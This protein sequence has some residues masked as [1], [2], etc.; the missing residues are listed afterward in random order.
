MSS[1]AFEALVDECFGR[2]AEPVD[3]VE[4]RVAQVFADRRVIVWEGDAQ[5]FEFTYV[6][7]AAEELLG[8]PASRWTTE[9]T[10]WADV[11]VAPA[12]RG[13]AIAYCALAT[14][15]RRHHA[16]D[17]RAHAADGR[18]VWLR[19]YVRVIVGPRGIAT[20]LR[21]LMFDVTGERTAADA[22]QGPTF[23]APS[24]AELA[25]IVS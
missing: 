3:A 24:L 7:S 17:Y 18:V 20:T 2:L 14:T 6:S 21:G 13:D 16:F 9:P 15:K 8:Y 23:R 10:F 4:R 19:D 25:A 22:D 11:V 12:D 1:K 5:T